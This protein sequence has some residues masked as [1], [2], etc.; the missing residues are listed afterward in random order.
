MN[1]NLSKMTVLILFLVIAYCLCTAFSIALLGDKKLISN[2][3]YNIQNIF[4]L[5]IN[6]KFI[7]SMTLAV[8]SRV[9]FILINSMLLKIPYLAGSATTVS[10]FITLLSIVFIVITNHY[11]LN[12][13]L[14]MR[15]GIGAFIVLAGIFIMLSK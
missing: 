1:Y 9:T 3:L 6:W 8:F 14:N 5:I 4:S 11:F 10:V 15:Q 13:T 7:L 2:N 12:E